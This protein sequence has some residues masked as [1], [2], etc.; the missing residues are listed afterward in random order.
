MKGL[1]CIVQLEDAFF[2]NFFD[3]RA[4]LIILSYIVRLRQIVSVL[5]TI[6]KNHVR[7]KFLDNMVE[8]MYERVT[9][10]R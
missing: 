5:N 10:S 4:V 3:L 9:Y 6:F 2:D 1:T 7:I 8:F